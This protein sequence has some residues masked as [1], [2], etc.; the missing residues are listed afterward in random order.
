MADGV[1]EAAR[2]LGKFRELS[3]EMPPDIVEFVSAR[4]REHPEFHE[5]D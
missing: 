3:A 1:F 2:V 5:T 4:L